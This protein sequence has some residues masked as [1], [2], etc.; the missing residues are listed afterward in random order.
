MNHSNQ[1]PNVNSYRIG[2]GDNVQIDTNALLR[3]SIY[4]KNL[5]QKAYH[6]HPHQSQIITITI[7]FCLTQINS[8][9]HHTPSTSDSYCLKKFHW[10]QNTLQLNPDTNCNDID[11]ILIN[12]C[13][14]WYQSIDASY[15]QSFDLPEDSCVFV[16]EDEQIITKTY[17]LSNNILINKIGFINI[18][19]P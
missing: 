9:L 16:L 4:N 17:I 8:I 7:H 3:N 6:Y 13:G 18:K 14:N 10:S 12:Y 1:F 2:T 19:R 15:Q 5:S 11:Y